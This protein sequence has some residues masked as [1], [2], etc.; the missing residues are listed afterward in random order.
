MHPKIPLDS[1]EIERVNQAVT[2]SA[3]RTSVR[4]VPVVTHS[5]G[6]YDRAEDLVGLWA[7][8]IALAAILVFFLEI[9]FGKALLPEGHV[10]RMGVLPIFAVIT[11]GFICGAFIVTKLAWLRRLFVPR[12]QLQANVQERARTVFGEY[13]TGDRKTP[14]VLIFASVYESDSCVLTD[15]ATGEHLAGQLLET[16]RQRINAGLKT[17]QLEPALRQSVAEIADT[18]AAA[19]PS[20]A[21]PSP[22]DLDPLPAR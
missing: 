16:I 3:A 9:P 7:A 12:R 1:Q 8:A 2:D 15:P 20:G 13:R 19:F 17:G 11:A 18:L 21:K 6:K 14:L 10:W 22:Q 5:S 4:I